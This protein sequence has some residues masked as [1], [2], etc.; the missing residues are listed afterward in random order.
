MIMV[1]LWQQFGISVEAASLNNLLLFA[2]TT[3]RTTFEWARFETYTERWHYLVLGVVCLAIV[4][5]VGWM[6]RRDSFELGPV[7][8]VLLLSLRVLALAGL[9]LYYLDPVKRTE[10]KQIRNSRALVLVDT[11]L[12]MGLHDAD[13][14]SVP[15]SPTRI[16]Q[17]IAALDSGR[18]DAGLLKQLR[19][20]HDLVVARFDSDLGRLL[21]IGKLN[22]PTSSATEPTPA[23]TLAGKGDE[24]KLPVWKEV[25]RPQGGETRLGQA[26]GQ[27]IAEERSHPLSGV[28]V[29]TDGGQNAGV[30]P[31]TVV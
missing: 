22:E 10:Q 26:L 9:L 6:Y 13:S 19:Q 20:K 24:P 27:L 3:S 15:A 5:F 28:I 4:A 29:F 16:E 18:G 11:S 25:L 1:Q 30:D 14:S 31:L 12:S 2:Q 23:D 8:R 7:R 21:S 17:V